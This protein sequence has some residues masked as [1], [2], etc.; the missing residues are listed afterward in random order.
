[1]STLTYRQARYVVL[2]FG[3]ALIAAVALSAFLRG[4]DVVEVGAIVLFVPVLVALAFRHARGGVAM[5]ALVSV[6]YVVVRFETLGDLDVTEFIGS[7]VVRV[8]LY[9]GLGL[10]GGWANA[11]LEHALHKLDL[12]DEIDDATGVGNARALLSIADRERARAERYGSVFSLAVLKVE[13]ATFDDVSERAAIRALR[14]LCQTVE[15]SVRTTDLVARIPLEEREDVVVVLPETGR[16][17]AEQFT[18]RLVV[19]ARDHLAADGLAADGRLTG[20]VVAL[21]ED[22]ERLQSYQLEVIRAL[23]HEILADEGGRR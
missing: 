11:M 9:L 8:L 21:P 16:A 5:A 13:R 2:G 1:M 17:G 22:E 14:R 12:Y 15:A 7:V 10:F 6:V 23:D 18:E 19:R 4:A 20:E 3:T